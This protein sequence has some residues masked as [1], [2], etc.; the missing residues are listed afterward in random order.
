MPSK[1]RTT[2]AANKDDLDRLWELHEQEAGTKPGRKYNVDVLNRAAVVMVC[3]AWEAYCEDIVTEA[4]AMIAADCQDPTL[5]PVYL[6]THVARRVK[7]SP[8]DHAPWDMAGDG[9][10][11]L[12][13]TNASD[14]VKKLTG[15]WNTPKT[16]QVNDLFSTSLGITEI[17][18]KWKWAKNP[19]DATKKKLDDFVSL[20]GEIAHRLKPTDSVRKKDGTDFY[21]FV[22]RLADIIDA[23]VHAVLT[24]A[25]TKTYW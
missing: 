24:A 6:K 21:D 10:R 15:S 9:W 7:T 13:S 12:L 3:A 20:R 22:C 19:V 25:T 17:S 4:I 5:L 11:T 16:A 14:A 2:L 1:A 8:H 23:D 18:S